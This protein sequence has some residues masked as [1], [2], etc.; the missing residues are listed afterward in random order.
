MIECLVIDDEPVARSIIRNYCSHLSYLHIMAECSNALEA[1]DILAT[2][3][4]DLLFLDIHMPVLSG[5]GFL[6]TLKDAPAIILTTA[7]QEYALSAFDFAV[8][9][10][11]LKPFS[12]ERFII[13]VE[14]AKARLQQSNPATENKTSSE[15][16]HV[17]LKGDG[18]LYKINF[19]E[20]LYAEAQ[21]NYTRVVTLHKVI[22]TKMPFSAVVEL[23]PA[24]LFI[25]THRS[26]IINKQHVSHIE[27]NR[28]FIQQNEIPVAQNYRDAFF[29]AIGLKF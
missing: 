14:K 11:L 26:F 4:A 3:K 22:S 15:A 10:Y 29:A 21:G 23:L 19:T 24:S 1:K 27:G 13:A 20:C 28:V 12:L 2:Q 17:F 7:F 25:R 6:K 9:D 8:C 18:K 5:I 16:D